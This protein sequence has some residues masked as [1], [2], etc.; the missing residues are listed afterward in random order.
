M[1]PHARHAQIGEAGLLAR[2][3]PQLPVDPRTEVGPGDDAAVLRLDSPRLVI[4]TD[5][6]VEGHDFLRTTTSARRVGR[7]AA[8]QNLADVAAMGAR[9][10]ALVVAISAPS[11]EP[12]STFEQIT[13]G[14]A[15]RAAAWGASVVGGD[16][17]GAEQLSVTITAVGSLPVEKPPI[18]RDGA[19]AGDLL[20]IGG[21]RLGRSAAGLA[22]A[23][24]GRAALAFDDPA[25]GPARLDP[26]LAATDAAALL[27]WHDAP[28]PDLA[29]GW[30]SGGAV[31]AQM[32][33]SD[34]LV[35]D[36]AR[37]AA[38]S[39]LAVDLDPALLAADVATLRP[40][41]SVLGAEPLDWVLHGGEEHLMLAAAAAVPA[42]FR[43]VGRF[44]L[45]REGLVTLDG[46]P[47]S[48]VGFDHFS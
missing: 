29:L 38:A 1:A 35:R 40:L 19:R 15:E 17:G 6:L 4:T 43:A 32:D 45:G 44:T 23:L 22:V 25:D 46:A 36:G 13:A 37:L 7:K 31:S 5:A 3:L 30:G 24:S 47:V 21:P 28:D 8:V 16:L 10:Q 34:G 41:A 20:V 14:I 42:G 18:R 12:P 33:L 11:D 48:G 2:M 27:E 39:G 9:P 26:E